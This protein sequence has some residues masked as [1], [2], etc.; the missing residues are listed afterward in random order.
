M[1]PDS[2]LDELRYRLDAE[3]IIAPYTHLKRSGRNLVGL[4]PF[5][6]EKS[7]SFFVYPE[8]NSF[9]CFGCGAGGDLISFIRRAENLDYVEAV[10]YLADRAGLPMPEDTGDDETGRRRR[11]ILEINRESARFFHAAL[12]SPQG[13]PGLDYLTKR[14]L[15]PNIIRRFGLGY[16]PDGWD[17][18]KKH[19]LS[20]GFAERD[21]IDAAVLRRRESGGSYDYFR[22]RVM[23]PI[24]DLRGGVVGFGG[25]TLGDAKPKYLNTG[26]TLV[27]KKSRGLFAM[28]FAKATKE[29]NLIL[30]EGYMDAISIYQGGF[31][32]AV[33]SC[34][35][36]LT[37]EQ[38]RLMAQY[39]SEVVV[40]YDSD[41]PGQEATRRAVRIFGGVGIKVRV[42]TV[43]GAKDP[44]E[45]LKKY[46]P[47]RFRELLTGSANS[48][49]YAIRRLRE[50]YDTETDD[51]KVGFMREFCA[52]MAQIPDRI[53]TDVYVTRVARE[54]NV[55]RDATAERI[56]SLRS[57]NRR[58]EEKKFDASLR[59]FAQEEPGRQRDPQRGANLRYAL[60]EDKLIGILLH[61]PD[62]GPEIAEAIRPEEFVTE[63]NR[64]IYAAI[65]RRIG[66]GRAFD[67]MSLSG[68]LDDV[69]MS[70]VSYLTISAAGQGFTPADAQEYIAVL[71]E[72]QKERTEEQ[73]AAMSTDEWNAY[74]GDIIAQKT[75]AGGN[76]H[77]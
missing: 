74:I 57:R 76:R 77:G 7:P 75:N 69:Q 52:L 19:L 63:T 17:G 54:L 27:F 24:I 35:T 50:R 45:F 47:E 60:A 56:A 40:A 31:D 49:E 9:Y 21:M 48:T 71:R 18:L 12:L 3:Q 41:G 59:I 55:S 11:T 6:S 37:P 22:G 39:T 68:E 64:A 14:G 25:R 53:E 5:H 29:T 30:C 15:S 16:A 33:A 10:K 62:Y 61:N 70:R 13:K 20:K 34:G 2:F 28:N 38:A 72:K 51:G 58:R 26:D 44:D 73:V 43:T 42:L 23:F 32:N 67:A 65:A 4:C 46:G 8:N 66:E 36:A 1:I